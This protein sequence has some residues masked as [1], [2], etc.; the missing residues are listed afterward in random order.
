MYNLVSMDKESTQ[1]ELITKSEFLMS[2]RESRKKSSKDMLTIS[3]DSP[4]VL[5]ELI[6]SAHP[7]TKLSKYGM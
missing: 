5:M 7:L 6:F 3:V 4:S 2:K 1:E